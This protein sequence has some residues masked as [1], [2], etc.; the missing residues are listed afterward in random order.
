MV[1]VV[2]KITRSRMMS[3]IRGTNTKPELALRRALHRLGL[4]FRLHARDL[5][6]KP[7]IVLPKYRAAIQVHG[8]FWHR[9]ERCTYAT[10]PASNVPFWETKFRETIER[11]RRMLDA[12]QQIGWRIAIVWE[13]AI[14]THG[15]DAVANE[16]Y[17]WVRSQEAYREIPRHDRA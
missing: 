10:T 11:D 5:P 16:V 7:D 17:A 14:K 12:T 2:D 3:G 9:H 6:G 1:D 4:R 8:C 15:A 13:C